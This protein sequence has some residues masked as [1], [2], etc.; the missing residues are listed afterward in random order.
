PLSELVMAHPALGED[1]LFLLEPGAAVTRRTTP[2]GAG[3]GPV[4]DQLR[5]FRDHLGSVEEHLSRV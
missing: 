2:G 3:P 4:A 1:A 5:R